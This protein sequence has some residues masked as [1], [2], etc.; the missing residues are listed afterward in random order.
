M[1]ASFDLSDT[2]CT[3]LLDHAE[4][5]YEMDP[6]ELNAA[7]GPEPPNLCI[8]IEIT[9]DDILV[10]SPNAALFD[11]DKWWRARRLLAA[12]DVLQVRRAKA[13]VRGERKQAWG[14]R[15]LS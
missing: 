4:R 12:I 7:R 5:R 9:A 3:S 6:I 10:H 11:S 8:L 14:E 2:Q 15:K 13:R 1:C